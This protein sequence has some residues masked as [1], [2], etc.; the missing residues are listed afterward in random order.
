M[1]KMK[2]SGLKMNLNEVKEE[3]AKKSILNSIRNG[4]SCHPSDIRILMGDD[5]NTKLKVNVMEIHE[6]GRMELEITNL[7]RGDPRGSLVDRGANGGLA[8]ADIRVI[9]KSD[10]CVDIT[11]I[12]NH[13]MQ[14]L[15]II[16]AGGT[17]RS[18]KGPIIV[19]MHIIPWGK[20]CI[21]QFSWSH[22][23]I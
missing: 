21:Q 2:E 18:D 3:P 9:S 6:C 12:D 19:I 5:D 10:K 14:S 15:P 16:T 1:T 13:C 11:G 4:D 17:T 22:L 8:G 7:S 23:R 20:L